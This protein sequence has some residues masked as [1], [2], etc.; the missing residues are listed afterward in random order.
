MGAQS[1]EAEAIRQ[2]NRRARNE[3][4]MPA[5][6]QVYEAKARFSEFLEANGSEGPQ[7]MTK[8]GTDKAARLSIEE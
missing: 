4:I 5:T 6:W 2:R 8:R 3:K 1:L 7:I